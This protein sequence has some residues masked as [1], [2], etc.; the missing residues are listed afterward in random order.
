MNSTNTEHYIEPLSRVF[1][2]PGEVAEAL[3]VSRGYIYSLMNVGELASLKLGG[4]RLIPTSE[5]E[6][7][8]EMA[9]CGDE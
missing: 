4:R 5:L 9:R 3:G 6:R 2:S 1:A 8:S 7:L